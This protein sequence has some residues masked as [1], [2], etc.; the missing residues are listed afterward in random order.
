MSQPARQPTQPALG[1][2]GLKAC[3]ADSWASPP[4]FGPGVPFWPVTAKRT[5]GVQVSFHDGEDVLTFHVNYSY[6]WQLPR[7]SPQC[8]QVPH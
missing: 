4:G 7:S 3:F 5:M 2:H 8:G 6:R 1:L